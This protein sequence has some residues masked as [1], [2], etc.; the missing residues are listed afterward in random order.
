MINISD[1]RILA[2]VVHETLEVQ[3]RINVEVSGAARIVIVV[4]TDPAN[5]VLVREKIIRLIIVSIAFLVRRS[6]HWRTVT[7]CLTLAGF[8]T[9]LSQPGVRVV[10]IELVGIFSFQRL[11]NP[12][13]Q[14]VKQAVFCRDTIII[15]KTN[16]IR[17]TGKCLVE[18]LQRVFYIGPKAAL[19]RPRDVLASE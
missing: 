11:Q 10:I 17:E 18:K 9:G 14:L 3:H 12:Q 16:F 15:T 4:A 13:I 19:T 5:A 6:F 8:S 1:D 7:A 2:D